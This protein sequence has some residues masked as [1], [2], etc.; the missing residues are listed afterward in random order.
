MDVRL[1]ISPET[2]EI[3][4]DITAPKK[5]D[6]VEQIIRLLNEKEMKK[7]Y[8]TKDSITYIINLEDIICFYTNEK[9]VC[10]KTKE[11]EFDTSYRMYELENELVNSGFIRISNSV[12]AN[13]NHVKCFDTA[14]VGNIIVR[15]DDGNFEYVSK[16]K[17]STIMK[18]LRER[19]NEL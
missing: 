2:K 13:I 5:D 15:F 19:R 11:G 16:R 12:I 1:N 8:A 17:I 18:Y 6:K 14:Q 3:T 9:K 4:V 10:C 7:I